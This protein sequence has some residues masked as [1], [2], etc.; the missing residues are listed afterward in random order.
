MGELRNSPR[1]SYKL[2]SQAE[3]AESAKAVTEPT[4]DSETR[5]RRE[6]RGQGA[7]FRSSCGFRSYWPSVSRVPAVST[8]D[9]VGVPG[10]HAPG[11]ARGSRSLR[12]KSRHAWAQSDDTVTATQPDG[13][14]SVR[15]RTD[16]AALG[17]AM[18]MVAPGEAAL[19]GV[20][21]PR[22]PLGR[23]LRTVPLPK[24]LP[25]SRSPSALRRE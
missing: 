8:A 22:R 11:P 16:A 6:L 1:A 5:E 18:P 3:A 7:G 19:P 12:F 9:A 10:L 23:K 15:S 14:F 24:R 4:E 2:R 13:S 20:D 17:I 21:A 25:R